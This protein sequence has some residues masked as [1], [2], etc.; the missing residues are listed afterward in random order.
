MATDS[1]HTAASQVCITTQS[2]RFRLV[3]TSLC[4]G[5]SCRYA[6]AHRC[7]GAPGSPHSKPATW[8]GNNHGRN[9]LRDETCGHANNVPVQVITHQLAGSCDGKRNRTLVDATRQKLLPDPRNGTVGHQRGPQSGTRTMV[10]TNRDKAVPMMMRVP[11]HATK[12]WGAR[13]AAQLPNSNRA[14]RHFVHRCGTAWRPPFQGRICPT[15]CALAFCTMAPRCAQ[16]WYR[17]GTPTPR[18]ARQDFHWHLHDGSTLC[19]DV[20]T[21]WGGGIPRPHLPNTIALALR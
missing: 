9:E 18:Q 20:G 1:V 15:Q 2:A 8:A 6:V 19:T 10:L 7:S 21:A 16:M 13:A 3:V 5:F 4:Q 11:L 12:V 14:S 17:L